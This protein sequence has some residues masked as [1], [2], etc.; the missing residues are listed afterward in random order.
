MRKTKPQITLKELQESNPLSF[1]IV[2]V[3]IQKHAQ[4]MYQ[5]L[6]RFRKL[7]LEK[8]DEILRKYIEEGNAQLTYNEDEEVFYIRHWN[9]KKKEYV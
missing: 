1:A 8:T 7:G 4:K 9:K 3:V 6:P 5:N 2:N